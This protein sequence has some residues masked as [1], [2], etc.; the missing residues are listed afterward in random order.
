MSLPNLQSLAERLLPTALYTELEAILEEAEGIFDQ[1]SFDF[2]HDLYPRL[3]NLD[4]QIPGVGMH[5]VI[6]YQGTPL[7]P[8][9]RR[10][11]GVIR[12]LTYVPYYL[13]SPRGYGTMAR[14][15]IDACGAHLEQCAKRVRRAPGRKPLGG[16]LSTPAVQRRLGS[17]LAD[18]LADF[19]LLWGAAKHNY[20]SGGPE[21]LFS[22]PDAIRGYYL[23]RHLGAQVLAGTDRTALDKMQADTAEAARNGAFYRKGCLPRWHEQPTSSADTTNRQ[24]MP[25]GSQTIQD[26]T[27]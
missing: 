16:I 12:P 2:E 22:L 20:H 27:V 18:V 5:D 11:E 3:R 13:V 1:P 26:T 23:A 4:K 15:V 19:N 21:S 7:F 6:W 25:I 17:E 10:F 8:F 14:F 9:S 24:E